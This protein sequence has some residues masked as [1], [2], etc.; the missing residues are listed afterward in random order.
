MHDD[1]NKNEK[2]RAASSQAASSKQSFSV[3]L[4]CCQLFYYFWCSHYFMHS[5]SLPLYL[6]FFNLALL[7][8]FSVCQSV[9]LF[10][11]FVPP[12]L[13]NF[14]LLCPSCSHFF[15]ICWPVP[16]FS[17]YW[18]ISFFDLDPTSEFKNAHQDMSLF[19]KEK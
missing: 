5:P 18:T 9:R 12:P 15:L 3:S 8:S 17:L 19:S 7:Y 10:Y 14:F 13:P 6:S 4:V 11:S 1:V 2:Q 16:T